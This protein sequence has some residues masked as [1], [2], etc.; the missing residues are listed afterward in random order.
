MALGRGLYGVTELAHYVGYQAGATVKPYDVAR[1][2]SRALNPVPHASRR[3][4]YSFHDLVSL[5]VVRE[6]VEAGVRPASI[7]EA[8]AYLRDT[9]DMA[10]PFASVRLQTDGVNVL[11]K[12]S[13]AIEDQLTAA[14]RGGQE[15]SVAAIETALRSVTFERDVAVRWSPEP[16]VEV[17]PAVQFGA[18]HVRGTR[19][20]TAHLAELSKSEPVEAVAKL[21]ELRPKAVRRA[22][23]FEERLAAAA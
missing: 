1:W 6:L 21:Y 10:R 17:D 13:P 22:L 15:V 3:P 12:A 19:I 2:L 5:F 23:E 4:D 11:Y 18:P 8:E 9:L 7:R 14:N 20:A 16:D